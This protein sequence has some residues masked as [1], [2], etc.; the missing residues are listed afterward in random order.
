MRDYGKISTSIWRS[1]KFNGL[2]SDSERLFYFYLHT[3]QHVNS[4]GCYSLPIGYIMADLD[5]TKKA[6]IEAIDSLSKA[7]LIAYDSE[8]SL[9]RLVDYLKHDQFTNPKHAAGAVKIAIALP[10]CIEKLNLFVDIVADNF[11][12]SID[13][14]KRELHRLSKAYRNPGTRTRTRTRNPNPISV[15][16]K[17]SDAVLIFDH[18][19][20]VMGHEKSKLDDKRTALIRKA[21]GLGYSVDDLKNAITGYSLS[22]FHMGENDSNTR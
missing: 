20:S 13:S 6:A 5:W 1:K 16:R 21:L 10:D 19:R 18:W 4:V 3:C 22:P 2:A 9:L 17:P 7:G 8:E 15:E 14:A 12:A 11:A